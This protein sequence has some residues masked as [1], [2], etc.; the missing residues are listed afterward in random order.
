MGSPTPVPTPINTQNTDHTTQNEGTTP[1]EDQAQQTPCKEQPRN[2][3]DY[4]HEEGHLKAE[5]W[6]FFNAWKGDKKTTK[7][8]APSK[9]GKPPCDHRKATTK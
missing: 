1:E 8:Q 3:T 2:T 4:T 9:K 6:Q 5:G 7:T